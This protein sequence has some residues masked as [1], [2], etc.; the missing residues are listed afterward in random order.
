[1]VIPIIG[2]VEILK[3]PAGFKLMTYRFIVNPLTHCTTLFG[4]KFGKQKVLKIMLQFMVDFDRKCV[5]IWR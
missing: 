3:A 5:T 4:N 2:K 1:M